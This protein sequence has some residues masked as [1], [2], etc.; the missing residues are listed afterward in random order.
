MAEIN[1]LQQLIIAID[2]CFEKGLVAPTLALLFSGI[3]TMAW[4]GLPDDQEDVTRDEFIRWADRY[5]LPESGI[6]CTALDLYSARCG[7]LHSMT[8]ESRAIRTG[9]AK[10]VFYAWGT[11]R[12]EDLQQ[13]LNRIGEP[14]VALQV[15]ALIKAFRIAIDKFVEA[16]EHDAD[17]GR[18]INSR[19]NKV[20]V[21][22]NFSL[23]PD[24]NPTTVA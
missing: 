4:L 20:F 11:H 22:Y 21:S 1:A 17:L 19:L 3:D 7:I 23:K 6:L 2:L 9:N 13:I 24:P 10:R 18:R 12:F 16:S 8:A 5:L 15:D 14:I